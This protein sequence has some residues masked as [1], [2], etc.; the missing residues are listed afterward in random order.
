VV[1]S[2]RRKLMFPVVVS[3][4]RKSS[5]TTSGNRTSRTKAT[6]QLQGTRTS[7][8]IPTR[9]AT[10][11]EREVTLLWMLMSTRTI[12]MER[13]FQT[14][15]LKDKVKALTTISERKLWLTSSSSHLP[16]Q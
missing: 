15:I 4:R 11:Q 6:A 2:S 16:N 13:W 12:S 8:T 7:E 3:S 10:V 9:G 14:W 5:Q 1:R